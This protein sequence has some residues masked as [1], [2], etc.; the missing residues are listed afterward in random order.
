MKEKGEKVGKINGD[1][2]KK[3]HR[4]FGEDKAEGFLKEGVVD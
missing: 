4:H 1:T 2:K 3:K